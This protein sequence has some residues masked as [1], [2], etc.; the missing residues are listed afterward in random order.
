LDGTVLVIAI[1]LYKKIQ[2]TIF[3]GSSTVHLGVHKTTTSCAY[4]HSCTAGESI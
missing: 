1:E 2:C 4:L 3:Y